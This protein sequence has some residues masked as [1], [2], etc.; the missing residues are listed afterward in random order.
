[1][2]IEV[3]LPRIRFR[4]ATRK[5]RVWVTEALFPNYLFARFDWHGSLRRVLHARG[6]R[7]VVH[8]GNRWPT[9]AGETISELQRLASDKEVHTIP[10]E[11]EEGQ[12][13]EIVGGPFH[14]LA[15]VVTRPLPSRQRVAVLLDFL[16]RQTAV[17]VSLENVQ[18]VANPRGRI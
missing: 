7:T 5:G 12:N 6:V 16:G 1:M 9:I 11:L 2:G 13:V 17:E 15:A 10:D 3:C 4:R 14:G 18:S 8:F